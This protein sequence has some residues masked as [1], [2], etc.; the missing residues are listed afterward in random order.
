MG[1][2][3][4]ISCLLLL[5]DHLVHPWTICHLMN[6]MDPRGLVYAQLHRVLPIIITIIIIIVLNSFINFLYRALHHER[7]SNSLEKQ[8]SLFFQINGLA[9]FLYLSLPTQDFPAGLLLYIHMYKIYVFIYVHIHT[10]T[11]SLLSDNKCNTYSMY[12]F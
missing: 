9:E 8:D 4:A 2:L 6:R 12:K 3:Q 5:Y 7:N 11:Y 1:H 10:H